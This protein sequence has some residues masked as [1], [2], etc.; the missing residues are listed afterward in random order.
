LT[1]TDLNEAMFQNA[2][3]KFTED[4]NV[5]WLQADA[6]SLP[7]ADSIF[8]AVVCQFGIMFVPDKALAARE[9]HRV[10]K[11]G[12]SFLFNVWDAIEHNELAQLTHQIIA[13]YFDKDPPAFY[14]VPFS[15]HDREEIKR[16]FKNAGFQNIKTEV[17]TKLTG[18]NRAEDAALGLIE[19]NPVAVAITEREPALLPV[20]TNAVSR[21][22]KSR[23]GETAFRV[24]MRAIAVEAQR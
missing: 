22:I 2:M 19:G 12:G 16:V 7:F 21:A 14:E 24:P 13:S 15:Y 9:A 8:D 10:L 1:A 17:V 23:F 5:Q 20:I 11:P 18:T 3:S 4:E 6:C